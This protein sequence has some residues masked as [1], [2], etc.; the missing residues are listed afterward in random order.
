MFSRGKYPL[1]F[2]CMAKIRAI[3]PAAVLGTPMPV[4]LLGTV[5]QL[6]LSDLKDR[7]RRGQLDQALAGKDP[8][9]KAYTYRLVPGPPWWAR[10]VDEA[11]ALD[12]KAGYVA[13]LVCTRRAVAALIPEIEDCPMSALGQK[14]TPFTASLYVRFTPESGHSGYRTACP[15]S[16]ISRE[17]PRIAPPNA[18]ND[19]G[20]QAN[21]RVSAFRL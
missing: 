14:R 20:S 3:V 5:A 1:R 17:E 4:G 21:N 13:Q 7:T 6:Y 16:A 12:G 11:E 2:G 19:A 15:L 8:G 9:G 10:H 18:F